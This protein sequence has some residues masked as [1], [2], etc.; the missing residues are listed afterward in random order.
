MAI[1]SSDDFEQLLKVLA[2]AAND[3]TYLVL[4]IHLLAEEVLY[5]F[6]RKITLQPECLD[7]ARLSF[8]QTIA[9]AQAFT[10]H[11]LA[12]WWG[13]SALSKL[14]R[15]RNLLAHNLQPKNLSDKLVDFTAF[16]SHELGVTKEANTEVKKHFNTLLGSGTPQ[17]LLCL[18]GLHAHLTARLAAAEV[19]G[20]LSCSGKPLVEM[21]VCSPS[22]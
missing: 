20:V 12:E 18:V 19:V 13:W 11:V 4:K 9:L 1:E 5:D 15:L 22:S 6:L 21:S 16:V 2:P 3:P 8:S 14:N 10:P 7:E 17:F